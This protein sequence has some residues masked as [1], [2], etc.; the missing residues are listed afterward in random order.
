MYLEWLLH[1]LLEV[2]KPAILTKEVIIAVLFVPPF[3]LALAD[4]WPRAPNGSEESD[5]LLKLKRLKHVLRFQSG[6]CEKLGYIVAFVN[7]EHADE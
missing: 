4:T 6:D 1:F 2:R 7:D 3:L 5:F